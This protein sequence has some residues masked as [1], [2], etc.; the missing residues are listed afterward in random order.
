M[1]GLRGVRCLAAPNEY[2]AKRRVVRSVRGVP[3]PPK[4]R[5]AAEV[6]AFCRWWL[7][8]FTDKEI[9]ELAL[10]FGVEDASTERVAA[11]RA[12]LAGVSA[13]RR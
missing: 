12:W 8:R 1:P 4:E 6:A 3:L 13:S 7:E 9:A 11:Q 10:A 2:R 5:N